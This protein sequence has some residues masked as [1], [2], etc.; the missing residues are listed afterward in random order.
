MDLIEKTF[1]YRDESRQVFFRELSAGEQLKLAAGSRAAVRDG[2]SEL[3]LDFAA[4]GERGHRLVQMTLVTEDGKP[5][6]S[7]LAK[8]QEEKSSKIAKLVALAR[9]ASS[10]F[11]KLATDEGEA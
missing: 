4:E 8:L 6:Y 2:V 10:E 9:E 11:S 3:T 1:S 7:S 5:V